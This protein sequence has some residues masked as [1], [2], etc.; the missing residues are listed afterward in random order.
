MRKQQLIDQRRRDEAFVHRLRDDVIREV[1]MLLQYQD[2]FG[3]I[4]WQPSN[5]KI[6]AEFGNDRTI[7]VQI[8][9]SMVEPEVAE[10]E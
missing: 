1:A 9:V 3:G 10:V 8:Y 4:T 7:R 2:G 6:I 5:S